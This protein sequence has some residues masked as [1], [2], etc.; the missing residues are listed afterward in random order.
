[1]SEE[2]K[3]SSS[4]QGRKRTGPQGTSIITA[5]DLPAAARR[6]GHGAAAPS[7]RSPVLIGLGGAFDGRRFALAGDRI[8]VGR[9]EHNDIVLDHVDISWEHAQ[10]LHHDGRWWVLNVLSTNGTFVNGDAV[11][12]AELQSG[13]EVAFGANRFAF[14]TADSGHDAAAANGSGRRGW[15]LAGVIVTAVLLSAL[16]AFAL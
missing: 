13:D 10:I 3:Q 4:G 6:E 1:M 8:Q 7:E 11:H 5:A 12:E 14:R 9:R 15:L 16:L 2:S